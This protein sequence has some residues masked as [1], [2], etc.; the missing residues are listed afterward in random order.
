MISNFKELFEFFFNQQHVCFFYLK[1]GKNI[2]INTTY[3][4]IIQP[5]TDFHRRKANTASTLQTFHLPHAA[6]HSPGSR[7]LLQIS[8][9]TDSKHVGITEPL[10][11]QPNDFKTSTLLV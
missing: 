3:N 5:S 4:T 7:Y 9:D 8:P 1:K 6:N 10:S 11:I 2:A